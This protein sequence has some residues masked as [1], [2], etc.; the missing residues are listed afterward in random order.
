MSLFFFFVLGSHLP[1]SRKLLGDFAAVL[2]GLQSPIKWYNKKKEKERKKERIFFS[3]S[4]ES[5]IVKQSPKY[6]W[7]LA[8]SQ[9]AHA[10]LIYMY[11][12]II[13]IFS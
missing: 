1:V 2:G 11:I 4:Q 12:Y 7:T 6:D 3:F 9:S 5:G 8:I 10:E 13:Y